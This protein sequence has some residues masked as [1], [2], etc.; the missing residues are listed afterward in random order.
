MKREELEKLGITE[1][2]TI[3]AILNI[4]SSDIGKAKGV[5][6]AK[7]TE[8]AELRNQ[9]ADR[10]KD[11][12]ELSVQTGNSAELQAQLQELQDKY[13]QAQVE[14]ETNRLSHA[15]DLM[16][17]DSVHD[18]S[19]VKGQLD[20]SKLSLKDGAVVGLDEQINPLKETK[21]FLFK[22]EKPKENGGIASIFGHTPAQTNAANPPKISLG[23]MIGQQVAQKKQQ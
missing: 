14:N 11:I 19:I 22:Q 6:E 15:I 13:Q 5:A 1:K 7:E 18:T 12:K 9:L 2:E 3:D 4:N 8:L 16:L 20:M 10:D 17:L 23:T 21:G